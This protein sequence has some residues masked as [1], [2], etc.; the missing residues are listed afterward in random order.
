MARQ[1]WAA[2][3]RPLEQQRETGVA[4]PGRSGGV[5]RTQHFEP[6][7]IDV[8]LAAADAALAQAEILGEARLAN[9]RLALDHDQRAALAGGVVGVEHASQLRATSDQ[10]QRAPKLVSADPAGTLAVPAS[11]LGADTHIEVAKP[12][13][14][15]TIGV[16][17]SCKS[18]NMP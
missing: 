18:R 16:H 10:R 5:A 6:C 15:Q 12:R 4:E 17:P 13:A 11:P 7:L 1:T 14:E 3:G 9:A 2:E 8:V